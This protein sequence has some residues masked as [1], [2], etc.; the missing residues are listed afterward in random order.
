M[1]S[2]HSCIPTHSVV[3]VDFFLFVFLMVVNNV[4]VRIYILLQLF[5]HT[6]VNIID[7]GLVP[8]VILLH[9]IYH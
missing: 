5:F 9:Y 1:A 2:I 6:Q 4:M 8:N 7:I 3:V